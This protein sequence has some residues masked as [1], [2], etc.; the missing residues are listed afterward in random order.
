MCLPAVSTPTSASRARARH[1]N[2]P[3]MVP[4]PRTHPFT[5]WYFTCHS[6]GSS[7]LLGLV[8][9]VVSPL[10]Q[11]SDSAS[12]SALS[13][14]NSLVALTRFCCTASNTICM[15]TVSKC[16]VQVQTPP[17]DLLSVS[18]CLH[19]T[20]LWTSEQHSGHTGPQVDLSVFPFPNLTLPLISVSINVHSTLPGA[21]VSSVTLLPPH[22]PQQGETKPQWSFLRDHWGGRVSTPHSECG[23]VWSTSQLPPHPRCPPLPSGHLP[24]PPAGF[25]PCPSPL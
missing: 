4:A 20:A 10:L 16:L 13:P 15:L 21:T 22:I 8:F 25:P 17:P 11:S 23:H 2:T 19:D 18:S 6:H 3:P 14:S 1:Q 24:C 12:E 7:Q 5:H 9:S